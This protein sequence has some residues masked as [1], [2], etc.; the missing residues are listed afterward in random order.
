[1]YATR[2]QGKVMAYSD[3]VAAGVIDVGGTKHCFSLRDWPMGRA[4]PLRGQIVLVEMLG[5]SI[6]KIIVDDIVLPHSA[7]EGQDSHPGSMK[8]FI[9]TRF[10]D[11][12]ALSPRH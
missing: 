12:N 2:Q 8:T 3:I 6:K 7:A 11:Q 9:E 5:K 10:Y 4:A 1:M